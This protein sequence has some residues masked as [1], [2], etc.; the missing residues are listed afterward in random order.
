MPNIQNSTSDLIERGLFLPMAITILNRDLEALDSCP[1]KLKQPYKQLISC[2][3][4]LAQKDLID[5]RKEL[6]KRKIKMYEAERDEA[7]TLYVCSVNGYEEKHRYFNPRIREQ[8]TTLVEFY[9]F[10]AKT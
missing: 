3:L 8:V 2:S 1:F 9:L 5:V 4:K 6:R 7:F 10:A